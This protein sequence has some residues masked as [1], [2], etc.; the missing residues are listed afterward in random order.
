MSRIL[1]CASAALAGLT[2]LA[3]ACGS[4]PESS[5]GRSAARPAPSRGGELVVSVRTEPLSFSWFTQH[6]GTTDVVTFLTQAR[7]V[8]VN[9]VTQEI[10]PWL[11][12][13]WTRSDDGRHYT[14]K[15]RPNLTFA[16]G[17]PFTAADVVFSFDAAYDPKGGGPAMADTMMAGGKRLI[18]TAPDPTTV[19]LSFPGDYAP[20][21][22]ILDNLPI[23]PKHKLEAALKAGTFQEAWTLSTPPHEIT[24][25]GP[26][27]LTGFTPRQ[28]LVFDR[29]ERYFRKDADGVSLPYLDRIVIEIVPDQNAQMLRL[30]T[31]Q[32]DMM[33]SEVRPEDYAALKRAADAGR[34]Q[35]FDLGVSLDPDSFWINLK[36]GAFGA[37][38]RARWLQSEELRHAIALAVD[39]R[40]FADVVFLGAG[41]PVFGPVTAANRKW[42]SPDVPR[43]PHDPARAKQ[44]LASIGLVD[45]DGDGA[46]DDPRGGAARFT[47][48]TMKGQTALER[49]AA[50]IRDEL[51]K[52]G[53]TVDLALLEGNALV[54]RLRAGQGYEAAYFHLGTTDT[55]HALNLEYWMSG[56]AFHVWHLG[57]KTPA[58]PWEARIDQLMARYATAPD[59]GERKKA[60]DEVQ[61]IFAEHLPILHFA[62]PRVF[63]AASARVTGLTPAVLRPQFLWSPDTIA[64]GK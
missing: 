19:V 26:F 34:I 8:R 22:R 32:S 15:L 50:V 60:F 63:A 33:T 30:E 5:G 39:R 47:L 57:Q 59:E 27:V 12:E 18:V 20:G 37:D 31:G 9:R 13:G 16:D 1:A 6:D 48:S 35:I 4:R 58:T 21:L 62:A 56:G 49:G 40:A 29:N 41:E 53:L 10:E 14:L 38:P 2:A 36:P 11:A 45:R 17:H 44:L 25:L 52:I 51:K 46:L 64:I 23:L 24:G 43:T 54:T 55:D 3:A 7:L 42:Y 61:R 28:R